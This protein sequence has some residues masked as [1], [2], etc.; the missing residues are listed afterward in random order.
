MRESEQA[1]H[2][3]PGLELVPTGEGRHGVITMGDA[4]TI[5]ASAYARFIVSGTPIDT[6][7]GYVGARRLL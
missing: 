3:P 2:L 7:P 6:I 5:H 4:I 1:R